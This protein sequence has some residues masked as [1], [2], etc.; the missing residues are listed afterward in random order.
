MNCFIF[1]FSFI[2]QMEIIKAKLLSYF[3]THLNFSYF[4]LN[5]KQTEKMLNQLK[6]LLQ[7]WMFPTINIIN[8]PTCAWNEEGKISQ[9]RIFPIIYTK[10]MFVIEKIGNGY[11]C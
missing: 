1:L 6:H 11:K 3:A 2:V 4:I 10:E 5:I 8:E 7:I 9:Y